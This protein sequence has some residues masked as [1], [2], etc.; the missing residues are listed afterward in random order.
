MPDPDRPRRRALGANG[1]VELTSGA[2][3]YWMRAYLFVDEHPYYTRSDATGHYRLPQVPPG[4]YQLVCWMPNWH[5]E[6]H[7]RDPET[8]VLTRVY[9]R[10]PVQQDRPVQ[11]QTGA[12]SAADFTVSRALFSR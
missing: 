8:T 4:Q 11:V 10:P 9:F 2:G 5:I 6:H 7:E 3:W 12:T 1:L